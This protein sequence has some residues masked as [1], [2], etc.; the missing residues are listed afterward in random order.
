MK[1]IV[2]IGTTG[3]GKTTLANQV[4]QPLGYPHIELD[5]LFWEP[6]WR[7]AETS[8]FRDRAEKAL[9]GESWV[10]DG[11]YTGK[12]ID[13]V[14]SRADT[15]VWLDYSLPVTTWRLIIRTLRRLVTQERL[16]SGNRERWRTLLS[17]DQS[18]L[19][20]AFKTHGKHLRQFPELLTETEYAHV[21]VVHHL[22]PRETE[23]WLNRE[24]QKTGGSQ[25]H[26]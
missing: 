20:W 24:K 13:I 17:A 6:N 15:L 14:W 2:I 16:W 11:N 26:P 9:E 8:A 1:R 7:E 21:R 25:T 10:V 19:L 18:L 5:A 23:E 22:T 3:T 4:G 12:V